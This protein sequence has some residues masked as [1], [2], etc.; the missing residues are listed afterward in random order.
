[1]ELIVKKHNSFYKNPT[2]NSISISILFVFTS[3]KNL[4]NN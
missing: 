2:D 3:G 1:M 4:N